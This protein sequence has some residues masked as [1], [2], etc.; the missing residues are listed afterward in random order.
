VSPVNDI[1]ALHG[2]DRGGPAFRRE[3]V[4]K[5]VLAAGFAR[6]D[7]LAHDFDVSLMTMHRDLDALANEGWLTKIRGGATANPSA[8][9]EAGVRE[10]TAAQRA[11]KAA[12]ATVA[13]KMLG[14]G[15]TIFLDDSTTV[16]ALVPHLTT[17]VPITIATNFVPVLA[18]IGD[19]ADVEL[20]VLGGQY[21]RPQEACFGMQTV[22]AIQQ[23]HADLFFMSTTGMTGGR[24]YHRSEITIMVRR[25]FMTAADRRV[26]LVDHA[27]LGRRAPHLLCGVEDFDTVITD[28]GIDPEDLDDLRRR[29]PDVRVAPLDT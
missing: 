12:I 15:Q 24:C 7:E 10:R 14:Y 2:T 25:A 29:C 16:L 23:L 26:L 3:A 5:R 13:A 20:Y 8:L 1:V 19:T 27:K 17:H 4:R 11:E 9:L 28:E 18:A 6:I 22:E 21:Y